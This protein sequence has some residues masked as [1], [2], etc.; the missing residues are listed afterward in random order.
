MRLLDKDLDDEDQKS[1][2]IPVF[3][4]GTDWESVVF[5][6]EVNLEKVWKYKSK[7]DVVEYLQGTPQTCD[8]KYALKADKMGTWARY[9][10]GSTAVPLAVPFFC[11]LCTQDGTQSSY[12][13]VKLVSV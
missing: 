5:E 8:P 4:D 11:C 1:I 2:K 9:C 7:M 10:P 6:L 3:S 12:I 13:R